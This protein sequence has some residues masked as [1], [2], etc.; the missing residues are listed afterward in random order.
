M[1]TCKTVTAASINE[2]NRTF[3]EGQAVLLKERMADE[4]IRSIAFETLQ[5]EEL[6]GL[7]LYLRTSLERALEDAAKAKVR[8]QDELDE[9]FQERAKK[10]LS[11]QNK[12]AADIRHN[13]PG[14][15]Q[16]Q[17]ERH[18]RVR[19]ADAKRQQRHHQPQPG[20]A[21]PQKVPAQA[22]HRAAP[23]GDERPDARQ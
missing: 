13:R 1:M 4:N 20:Q 11:A 16:A 18:E 21:R 19:V 22:F 14:D 8:F 9:T 10:Q 3:W 12:K 6:K 7:P 23:P 5:S 15:E 2:C 17:P